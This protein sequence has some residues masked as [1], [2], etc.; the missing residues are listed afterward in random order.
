M[1][2]NKWPPTDGT[3]GSWMEQ[4]S[5]SCFVALRRRCVSSPPKMDL[6]SS[7][8]RLISLDEEAQI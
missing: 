1:T 2:T 5:T 3:L 7:S 8:L 4:S 6:V